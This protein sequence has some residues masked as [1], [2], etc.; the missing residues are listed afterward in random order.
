MK[1]VNKLEEK[2]HT[3]KEVVDTIASEVVDTIASFVN[4]L[5]KGFEHVAKTYGDEAATKYANAVGDGL[6]PATVKVAD[7]DGSKI[8]DEL[9]RI[10]AM[11]GGDVKIVEDDEKKQAV[12]MCN[13][14]GRMKRQ[15]L[16]TQRRKDGM[17]YYC[18]HCPLWWEKQLQELGHNFVF[19]YSEEGP[20]IYEFRKRK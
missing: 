7:G 1:G 20:C 4:M 3:L 2:V 8:I 9:A 16:I 18:W 19:H 6:V 13:S 14:G 11:M 5:N 17:P 15:G 12:I 10:H